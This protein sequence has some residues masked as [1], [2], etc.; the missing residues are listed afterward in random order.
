VKTT[1]F[2]LPPAIG[3]LLGH[4][5]IARNPLMQLGAAAT[6]NDVLD[7]GSVLQTAIG[8]IKKTRA[9][10]PLTQTDDPAQLLAASMQALQMA[11]PNRSST[12]QRALAAALAPPGTSPPQTQTAGQTNRLSG[13]ILDANS[14]KEIPAQQSKNP[15]GT[16]LQ[17]DLSALLPQPVLQN[18]RTATPEPVLQNAP[19][20]AVPER[21]AQ[22]QAS[23]PQ[24]GPPLPPPD[25][26]LFAQNVLERMVARAVSSAAQTQLPQAAAA[27][28]PQTLQAAVP[29][30]AQQAQQSAQPIPSQAELT[31]R[32]MAAIAQQNGGGPSNGQ[33]DE[34]TGF[35]FAKSFEAPVHSANVSTPTGNTTPAFGSALTNATQDASPQSAIQTPYTTIDPQSIIEQV[36]KAMTVRTYGD[37][38]QMRISLQP[39]HLGD[40][41]MKLTV[42]GNTVSANVVAQNAN[43]GQILLA[44]QH[45]LAKTLADAGLSLGSFS[46]DV[47][48]G[49]PG[50]SQQQASQSRAFVTT[51]IASA[52][53][54]AEDDSSGNLAAFAARTSVLNYLV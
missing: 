11:P 19:R 15:T 33:G 45:Q 8:A 29:A 41:S 35:A 10:S 1:S 47:S 20:T 22:P 27:Q 6:G 12:L 7:F 21:V 18:V 50:F 37:T 53:N 31:A 26:G 49:N 23:P 17:A 51:G 48:G 40:V 36:V 52:A 5:P 44:N 46:V 16:S 43:V 13:T 4:S 9:G 25:N 38:S 39:Q 30:N 54:I 42:T 2:S 3:N 34:S 32:V 14:A 28:D 24:V